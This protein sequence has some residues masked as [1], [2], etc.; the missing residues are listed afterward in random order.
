MTAVLVVL[1]ALVVLVYAG[2]QIAASDH[3]AI[4]FTRA[5]ARIVWGLINLAR[6]LIRF[7]IDF[8]RAE[9]RQW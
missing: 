5:I 2:Q 3:P 6:N 8:V 9:V 4:Q 1:V 7:T